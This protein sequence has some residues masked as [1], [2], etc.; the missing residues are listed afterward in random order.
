VSQV[1]VISQGLWQRAFENDRGVIGRQVTL[2]L[3]GESPLR[4]FDAPPHVRVAIGDREIAAF[5]PSSDFEQSITLPADLL[6]QSEGRVTLASSRFFVPGA[7]GSG[8]Q[9]HLALRIYSVVV[10]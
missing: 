9:R 2:R 6:A 5:D 3:M 8:D 10:K 7:A 4:Y 1:A